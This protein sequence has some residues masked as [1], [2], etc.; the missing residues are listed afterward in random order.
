VRGTF[1]S[2]LICW[3][4]AACACGVEAKL[5]APSVLRAPTFWPLSP[6]KSSSLEKK[7]ILHAAAAC[8]A[9]A[10]RVSHSV[11]HIAHG[12]MVLD[13][14][15]CAEALVVLVDAVICV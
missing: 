11:S 6:R 4:A 7:P 9:R 15:S 3:C 12:V 14:S 13:C 5:H 10:R 1:V 8:V 2:V